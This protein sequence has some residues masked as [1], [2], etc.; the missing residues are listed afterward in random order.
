MFRKRDLLVLIVG[1][2]IM[3]VLACLLINRFMFHPVKGGYDKML[4][5]Y[6]DIGTNGVPIAARVIGGAKRNKVIMYCH[7]NA[8]D[9]TSIDGHFNGLIGKGYAIGLLETMR[10][11]A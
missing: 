5:G 7:G 8:E 1:L 9:M 4:D 6:V 11:V 2:T 3:Q 10:K